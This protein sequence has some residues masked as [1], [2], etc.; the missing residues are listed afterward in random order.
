MSARDFPFN[1]IIEA[2]WIAQPGSQDLFLRCP[3]RE[4]CY[5]GT[6]GPG[7]T[8]AMLMAFAQHCGKGYG[9]HW[10]GV[11][12]RREYKHLDDLVS[13]SKRWFNRL[14]DRPKFLSGQGQF[15]WVWPTGEELLFRTFNTPDDYWN[16][17]G[18]EYPFIGWEEL[19]SWPSI[20]CYESMMSCNRTSR[21]GGLP[22]Q[23]RSTTNPYGVG[24]NWV[25]AYFIDPA[26]YGVPILNSEGQA[27]V[28]LFGSVFENKYIDAEYIKTLRALTDPNK[29]KAWLYGSWDITSGGMFD[30][31]WVREKHVVPVFAMPASWRLDRAFD[32]GS[33]RPFS[34]GWWAECDGTP[35]TVGGRER[36]FP[37][38]T[39]IRFAEWYGCT[40]KPNEGLRMTSTAV[41]HGIKEREAAMGAYADRIQPGP[42]DSAIYATT[43]EVSIGQSMEN[44]GVWWTVADKRAGSRKNGLE[45]IRGRLE[46]TAADDIEKP[47][48]LVMENCRDWIRCVP[49]IARDSRDPDDVD[50]AAEDH[51]TDETRYRALAPNREASQEP[52]RM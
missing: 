52:L 45:L 2:I 31:L 5:S 8:D 30:D 35:A 41:A 13:K 20:D 28:C 24:H 36:H 26:P 32:W 39:L 18:H 19:T 42:A 40:G 46:A 4:V 3:F 25:K 15:K 17:H 12:F 27:R 14:K 29:R 16:Y 9:A 7:K 50:T 37:R 6:R 44:A 43:D 22:L 48:M 11:I 21:P 47:G 51:N 33:S 38:G 10:R 49:S 34:V 1:S 23:V